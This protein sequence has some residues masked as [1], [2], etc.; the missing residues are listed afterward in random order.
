MFFTCS[1][2]L[3]FHP[4]DFPLA[5][6]VWAWKWSGIPPCLLSEPNLLLTP[7]INPSL[8]PFLSPALFSVFSF[9]TSRCESPGFAHRQMCTSGREK[10]IEWR[11]KKKGKRNNLCLALCCFSEG[12]IHSRWRWGKLESE[13]R[14]RKK[15]EE[16]EE[17]V[18]KDCSNGFL[19][20]QMHGQERKMVL[21]Q[22]WLCS[23]YNR[24][25]MC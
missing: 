1:L 13:M 3:P 8:F 15:E 18:C 5:P 21:E 12:N 4:T 17:E 7:N 19:E 24:W 16:E 11:T 14:K 2:F 10:K 6:V 25:D 22:D 9:I 23:G 20:R